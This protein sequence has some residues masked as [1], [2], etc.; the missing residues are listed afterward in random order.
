MLA[1]I[2]LCSSIGGRPLSKFYTYLIHG[3]TVPLKIRSVFGS[4]ELVVTT[5]DVWNTPGCD[6]LYFS[7]I[8]VESSGA[9]AFRRQTGSFIRQSLKLPFVG[10][11]I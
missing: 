6:A 3:S 1:P 4:T 5:A 8:T 7:V 9:I 2:M 10:S 11:D